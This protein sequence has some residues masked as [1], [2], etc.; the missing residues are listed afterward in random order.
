[1]IAGR[2]RVKICGMTRIED[3]LFAIRHGVDALG[4]IF[5]YKS[6]RCIETPAARKIIASLPPF[7]DKVG[8]FVNAGIKEVV[9]TASIGLTAIQLHGDESPDYC[10]QLRQLLPCQTIIKAFRV[11]SDSRRDEFAVYNEVVDAFLLDTYVAGSKGGT[12]EIFDWSIIDNLQLQR[13]VLLAGGLDPENIKEAI[14]VA[15]PYC[16]DVN[17]G[18]EVSPGVKDHKKISELMSMLSS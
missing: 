10:S 6:P 8:V 2:T 16:L 15:H 9:D 11:G 7:I 4:F 14:E 12:G 5:Y 18:V 17:S 1:M 3:A 13:P